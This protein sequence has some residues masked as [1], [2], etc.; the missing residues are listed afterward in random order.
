[1]L[2][3]ISARA[4]RSSICV[5]VCVHVGAVAENAELLT[6]RMHVLGGRMSSDNAHLGASELYHTAQLATESPVI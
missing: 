5:L 1:M 4:H 3:S 6:V 2:T